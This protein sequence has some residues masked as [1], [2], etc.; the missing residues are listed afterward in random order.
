M[1]LLQRLWLR[2]QAALDANDRALAAT[3]RAEIIRI[4]E[5]EKKRQEW[6]EKMKGANQ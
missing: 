2:E 1:T 5:A 4:Q 3:I 6:K